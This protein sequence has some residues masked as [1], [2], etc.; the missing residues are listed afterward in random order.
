MI[1]D[2]RNFIFFVCLSFVLQIP[3]GHWKG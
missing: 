1:K 3:E 2:V